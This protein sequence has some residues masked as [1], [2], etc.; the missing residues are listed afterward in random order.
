[1]KLFHRRPNEIIVFKETCSYD[2]LD[3]NLPVGNALSLTCPAHS[4]EIY[5]WDQGNQLT[6]PVKYNALDDGS[7]TEEPSIEALMKAPDYVITESDENV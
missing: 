1:M 5:S 4:Q 7:A 6:Y 2:L 3:I